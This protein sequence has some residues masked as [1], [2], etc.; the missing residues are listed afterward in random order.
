M[1]ST[2]KNTVHRKK[3]SRTNHNW[4]LPKWDKFPAPPIATALIDGM[5]QLVLLHFTLLDIPRRTILIHFLTYLGNKLL[6]LGWHTCLQTVHRNGFN[7]PAI[8]P[9]L[10]CSR[11]ESNDQ[12]RLL[13][14]KH[15][16]RH[17]NILKM[18]KYL[19]AKNKNCSR[20]AAHSFFF[21]ATKV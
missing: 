8:R 9:H 14:Q 11:L 20:P 3:L 1:N 13:D 7:N 21:I 5:W 12:M 19:V 10:E 2:I 16:M 15:N 18:G 17:A 4:T 6:Y